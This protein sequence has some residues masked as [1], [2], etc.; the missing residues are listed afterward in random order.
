MR[1]YLLFKAIELSSPILAK[2]ALFLEAKIEAENQDRI[3]AFNYAV[4]KND[5]VIMN[6]LL[7]HG[8]AI[9]EST[10]LNAASSGNLELVR[11]LLDSGGKINEYT[12]LSAASSGSLELVKF[13][14]EQ[15]SQ[16][17]ELVF[18]NAL[19]SGNLE[20]VKFLLDNGSTI[21]D[22][23]IIDA[24]YSGNIELVQFIL[25]YNNYIPDNIISYAASSGNIK[26]IEFLLNLNAKISESVIARCAYDGNLE[27]IEF[28]FNKGGLINDYAVAS[29]AYTGNI[30]LLNFLIKNGGVINNYA[31]SNAA[32]HEHFEAAQF[33]LDKGGTIDN[34]AIADAAQFGNFEVIKFLLLHGA[35]INDRAVL[36]AL[37]SEYYDIANYLLDNGGTIAEDS[38][39]EVAKLGKLEA[40]KFLL[41]KNVPI[42][43]NILV[44]AVKSSNIEIIKFFLDLGYKVSDE[45]FYFAH[46]NNYGDIIELFSNDY[47]YS[48]DDQTLMQLAVKNWD[49]DLV[50]NLFNIGIKLDGI[51]VGISNI[52]G[53]WSSPVTE[54]AKHIEKHESN[55]HFLPINKNN[56]TNEN[57][58]AKFS[59]FINPGAGDSFP[60]NTEF[61]LE[62]LDKNKM[63]ENEHL[64]QSIIDISNKNHLPYLG[65]CSGSQHLILS[66]KGS[67]NKIEGYVGG[68]HKVEFIPGSFPYF[69]SLTSEEQ[70]NALENCILP[71]VSFPISTAH[72]FAGVHGKIGDNIK[73]AAVSEEGIVE[74]FSYGAFQIGTQFHPEN[75][76]FRPESNENLNRQRIFLDNFFKLVKQ[77]NFIKSYAENND[78]NIEELYKNMEKAEEFIIHRLNVCA[79]K[80]SALQI[81]SSLLL[82]NLL[83]EDLPS[84]NMHQNDYIE[85]V[86]SNTSVNNDILMNGNI[87]ENL[88]EI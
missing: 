18:S 2:L 37:R 85:Y 20:L 53:E 84:I 36:N 56:I 1:N 58:I 34:N 31:V 25:N 12:M 88:Y 46:K 71:K 10:I 26:L 83:Y 66:H 40:V 75:H 5:Y 43:D 74:A 49:T 82:N 78:L 80:N 24:C 4:E 8:A 29:A 79:N 33:L 6:I 50:E 72:N 60:R 42:N 22:Y 13:L 81:G 48:I 39:S 28:L 14:L 62:D 63:L 19:D 67:L 68:E 57:F 7:N 55:I 30:D 3:S 38:I 44:H 69:L 77:Y 16:I 73:L 23:S 87:R 32:L 54:M 21:N 15:K 61:T 17:N 11:F 86:I 59:G 51:F 45:A 52:N 76:Y 70:H 27:I 65:I 9:E 41:N 35:I 64:Y 47:N